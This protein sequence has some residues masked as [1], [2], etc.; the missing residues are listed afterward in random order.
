V[1]KP[2]D[3]ERLSGLGNANLVPVILDVTSQESVDRWVGL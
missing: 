3:A 2:A 1:R